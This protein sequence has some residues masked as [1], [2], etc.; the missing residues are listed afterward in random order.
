VR[1]T[2]CLFLLCF[3]SACSP[4]FSQTVS[5]DSVSE[6]YSV[7]K[8][9]DFYYSA[10]GKS[11]HL[12]NGGEHPGYNSFN[13]IGHPYLDTPA[14][15]S[16]KVFYDGTE[17]ENIPLMYDITDDAVIAKFSLLPDN[18]IRLVHEK[19][20]SFS[21]GAHLFVKLIPNA[22]EKD[23]IATGFYDRTYQGKTSV[24]IKRKKILRDDPVENGELKSRYRQVDEYFIKKDENYFAITSYE[25]LLKI[26][27]EKSSDVKKYLRK[28][29][30]KFKKTP[31]R[32]ITEA[33]KYYDQL[34]N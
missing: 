10:A 16:G 25:L 32:T 1:K 34:T 26:F 22:K 2:N 13:V 33:A 29:K 15:Q 7:N 31:E 27:A 3:Y 9:V 17:Y 6:K 4:L 11:T 28:N 30:I 24:F 19:I 14:L 18:N 12:Y 21:F 20:E 8:A 23:I 5:G